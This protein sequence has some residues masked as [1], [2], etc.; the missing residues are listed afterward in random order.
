MATGTAT[1]PLPTEEYILTLSC[2][3]RSG[4]VHAV[5]GFLAERGFNIL[6]SSQFGDPTSKR[7]FMRVHFASETT[8][9]SAS[10]ASGTETP[11]ASD[12]SEIQSQFETKVAKE[13]EMS[14]ELHPASQKPRVLILVSKIG[15]CLNDLLFRA[16]T[17]QLPITI[18]AIVSNHPDFSPLAKSYG[19][20][21]HHLP[22][23]KDTR[24][25]QE[26]EIL[27]IVRRESIDIVVLARYMQVLSSDLCSAL[28]GGASPLISSPTGGP[29]SLPRPI[30]TINIHHSFLPSFA[31][32]KPYHQA[33][34][35]GVKLIGATA[36]FVTPELDEGPII[37][38]DVVRVSH[39]MG[40]R[41]LTVK[42]SEVESRV[43]AA[44][45]GLVAGRRVVGNGGKTVVFN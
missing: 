38:Q 7:F 6:D 5:T 17:A 28:A 21:F 11:S 15:H 43:L 23:T 1:P 41:E 35:R 16:S 32:A 44:A 31:G 9:A 18:P 42:G 12:V 10:G 39:G 24:A 4:I 34:A 19:I 22:V 33:F 37:E 27:E 14:F 30:P 13:L 25:K 29:S 45:V 26:S 3:D 8:S 2:P 20:P 40:A 36:H